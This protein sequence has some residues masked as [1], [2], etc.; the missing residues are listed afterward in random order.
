VLQK[1]VAGLGT[2][3]VLDDGDVAEDPI[4]DDTLSQ[5]LLPLHVLGARREFSPQSIR[6]AHSKPKLVLVHGY[7]A[8]NG[9]IAVH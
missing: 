7:A 5:R 2:L 1:I 6:R 4:S 9:M 8:A 3:I